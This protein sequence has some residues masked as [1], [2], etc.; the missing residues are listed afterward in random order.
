MRAQN[1]N[2]AVIF[3]IEEMSFLQSGRG[4]LG[5]VH[6]KKQVENKNERNS[7]DKNRIKLS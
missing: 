2:F 7:R 3:S 6:I 5:S 1:I 4:P